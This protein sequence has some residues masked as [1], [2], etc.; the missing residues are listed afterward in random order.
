MVF[1]KFIFSYII[2]IFIVFIIWYHELLFP[3][4]VLEPPIMDILE[5]PYLDL[6]ERINQPVRQV[7]HLWLPNATVHF[8]WYMSEFLLTMKFPTPICSVMQEKFVN[9]VERENWRKRARLTFG[10]RVQFHCQAGQNLLS[11]KSIQTAFPGI[12]SSQS[13]VFWSLSECG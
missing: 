1:D 6:T 13:S 2:I 8:I 11:L 9:G 5:C 4:P 7:I 12:C 3:F 10:Q